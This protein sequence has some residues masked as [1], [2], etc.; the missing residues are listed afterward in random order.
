[1]ENTVLIVLGMAGSGKSSFC[2]R[3][4]SWLSEKNM[5]I[6][7]RTGLND[8]VCGVNLDPAALSV[9]MP[10]HYDIRETINIQELMQQKKLGPNGAIVASI[11]LFITQIDVFISQLVELKPRYTVID[12][13]GQI[14]MF[15]TSVS[16][17]IL[18]QCLSRTPGIRVKMVY[19]MDGERAQNPQCFIS[20]MLF[21]TSIRYRFQEQV[22]LTVNKS[23]ICGSEKVREWASGFEAFSHALPENSNTTPIMHSIALW[24]EEFYS[25]FHLLYV[26]AAT[27]MGK[28]AF[29]SEVEK[30]APASAPG[31][32]SA[33]T[34]EGPADS[35]AAV[36]STILEALKRTTILCTPPE[37]EHVDNSTDKDESSSTPEEHQNKENILSK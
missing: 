9:K 7:S 21:A 10:L 11:N 24:M 2:H 31:E 25:T 28:A 16:G 3:L 6:D 18:V 4:Y 30:Q 36:I 14:E 19:A 20:N 22:L 23:D 1:M 35:Q 8:L 29:L 26:S 12:T 33:S 15:T 17:Q 34:A 13:P 5:Q 27:G 32:K 37:S